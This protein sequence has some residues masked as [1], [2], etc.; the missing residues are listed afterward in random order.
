[1]IL[2]SLT[3]AVLLMLL[4]A[5]RAHAQLGLLEG[6]FERFDD[7]SAYVTFARFA[8]RPANLTGGPRGEPPQRGGI[9]GV[10]VEAL[11]YGGDAGAADSAPG[12]AEF[13]FA[14]GYAELHGFGSVSPAFDIVGA[15]REL[16]AVGVY[17]TLRPGRR[18]RPYVGLRS[19]LS[20]LHGFRAYILG[21]ELQ[22]TYTAGGSTFQAGGL[23]GLAAVFG[24]LTFFLEPSY[25]FRNFSGVEWAPDEGGTVPAVLPKSLNLSTY[26]LSFGAQVGLGGRTSAE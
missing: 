2:R 20:Q 1:M 24:D 12:W 11:F 18:L 23:V 3:A 9:Y 21:D 26:N 19:G 5:P 8:E 17:A 15:V 6:L 4:A 10:G 7:L 22:P 25:T 16:P 14:L 13:E